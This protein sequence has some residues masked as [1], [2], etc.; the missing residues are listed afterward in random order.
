LKALRG[1]VLR[2]FVGDFEKTTQCRNDNTNSVAAGVTMIRLQKKRFVVFSMLPYQFARC[3]KLAIVS[4]PFSVFIQ[5]V[6][7]VRCSV[8]DGSE[9]SKLLVK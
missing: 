7:A 9:K 5:Y 8:R 4:E 2:G 6:V 1:S 3:H